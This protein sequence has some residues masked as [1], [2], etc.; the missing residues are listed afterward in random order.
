MH[1]LR[2]RRAPD[3]RHRARRPRPLA[4]QI[5]K[6][7]I[8]EVRDPHR[9]RLFHQSRRVHQG[10]GFYRRRVGACP[11][12]AAPLVHDPRAVRRAVAAGRKPH[13][14]FAA[15]RDRSIGRASTASAWAPPAPG[16]SSGALAPSRAVFPARRRPCRRTRFSSPSRSMRSD[17]AFAELVQRW[18][19]RGNW[20]IA[21]GD[22]S[23]FAAFP[24]RGRR[25]ATL[26]L[27]LRG[28]GLSSRRPYRARGAAVLAASTRWQTPSSAGEGELR[29]L[30]GERQIP[31][32]ALALPFDAPGA[33]RRERFV[34]LNANPFAAFQSWLQGQERSRP[35]ARLAAAPVLARR[36]CRG[37]LAHP[38]AGRAAARHASAAGR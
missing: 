14:A 12:D 6:T 26:A 8:H 27:S 10:S 30:G 20:I 4:L 7:Q 3:C 15:L 36:A 23:A 31:E 19:A 32:R 34:Y 11:L 38:R 37:T 33:R 25:G 24:P 22:P 17:R 13:I 5:H 2:V 29:R 21:A 35:L 28:A 16:I 9:E 1:D 18:H